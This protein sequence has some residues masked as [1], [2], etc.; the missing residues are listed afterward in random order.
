LPFWRREEALHERLAREGGIVLPGGGQPRRPPWDEVGIHG[1]HR[2]REWDDVVTVEGSADGD[3]IAFVVLDESVLVESD[4]ELPD[5]FTDA[6]E[7]RL[8]PPYRVVGIRQ[9]E[10]VWALG[11]R[12]IET[13]ELPGVDGDE[14][15][16][17]A[18]DEEATLLV[19]GARVFGSV[20]ALEALARSR[21]LQRFAVHAERLDGDLWEVA[22]AAL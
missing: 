12:R 11:A 13:I 17:G 1:L 15:D 21:G 6:F 14:L 8:E 2:Q 10:G 19:D 9:D 22:V 18:G 20:P 5:S 3:E 7:G 4:G 16:L